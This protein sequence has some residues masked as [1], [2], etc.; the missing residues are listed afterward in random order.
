MV[1]TESV[2]KR[3]ASLSLYLSI[4]LSIFFKKAAIAIDPQNDL[5]FC[6]HSLI[7]KFKCSRCFKY[8]GNL[9]T[10]FDN[11]TEIPQKPQN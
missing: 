2:N 10:E 5:T 9:F 1:L 4:Y 7:H 8:E 3:I 6:T 11:Y